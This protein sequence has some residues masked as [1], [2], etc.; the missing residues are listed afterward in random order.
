ML[1]L[2]TAQLTGRVTTTRKVF[3]VVDGVHKSQ[4]RNLALRDEHDEREPL[5]SYRRI[6][7]RGEVRRTRTSKLVELASCLFAFYDGEEA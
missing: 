1:L 7:S 3:M 6:F 2:R 4:T 5:S